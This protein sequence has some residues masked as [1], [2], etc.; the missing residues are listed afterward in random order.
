[1]TAFRTSAK[2]KPP[3]ARSRAFH[4]PRPAWLGREVDAIPIRRHGSVHRNDSRSPQTHSRRALRHDRI[5]PVFC[6]KGQR[7]GNTEP[8]PGTA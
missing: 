1:V 6:P 8:S 4:A 7:G 3:S 2:M 5:L